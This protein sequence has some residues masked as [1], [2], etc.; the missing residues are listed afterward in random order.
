MISTLLKIKK[1]YPQLWNI[2]ENI[3]GIFFLFLYHKRIHACLKQNLEKIKDNYSYRFLENAD[4]NALQYFFSTQDKDQFKYFK[5]HNFDMNTLKRLMKN[6]SFFMMG[7]FDDKKL[8]GYFFLR[9]FINKQCFTGRIIDIS[10][11][12]RGI[13]KEMGRILLHSAWESKFRVFG[14]A[15]IENIRS[16]ASYKSIDDFKIISELENGYI[17]FEYLKEKEKSN[18][19]I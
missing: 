8:I 5:P 7:V 9:C 2:V 4:L 10:Y 14:T 3:N 1:R 17:Y 19:N 15:S 16:L 12:G 18:I 6:P 11:Q 13:S